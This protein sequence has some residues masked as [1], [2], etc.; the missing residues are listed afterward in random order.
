MTQINSLQIGPTNLLKKQNNIKRAKTV[1]NPTKPM[2][3]FREKSPH[4][5]KYE[6]HS[7]KSMKNLV[8]QVGKTY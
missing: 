7:I 2:V 1:I 4:K 8:K 6:K 5:F 3:K